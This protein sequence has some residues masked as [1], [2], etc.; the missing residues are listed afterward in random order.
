MCLV[1]SPNSELEKF[2]IIYHILVNCLPRRHLRRRFY[3]ANLSLDSHFLHC[4]RPPAFVRFF[5]ATAS[6]M[7][8]PLF[9]GV[10]SSTMAASTMVASTMVASKSFYHCSSGYFSDFPCCPLAFYRYFFDFHNSLSANL[11]VRMGPD[12]V[13]YWR[14]ICRRRRKRGRRRERE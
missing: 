10:T 2:I 8:T 9:Y 13:F 1:C 3:L 6:R 12:T 11:S 5:S 7:S 4:C 14:S